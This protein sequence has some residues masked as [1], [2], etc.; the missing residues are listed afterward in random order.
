VASLTHA[1]IALLQGV[2]VTKCPQQQ[3]MRFHQEAE[4]CATETATFGNLFVYEPTIFYHFS[5]AAPHQ[6]PSSARQNGFY[7]LT[8]RPQ[9]TPRICTLLH[10]QKWVKI[11]STFYLT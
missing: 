5:S 6:F 9:T 2:L 11:K 8:L 10:L 1:V 4:K 3:M 7:Q